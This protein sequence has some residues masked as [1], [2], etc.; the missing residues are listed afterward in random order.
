MRFGR[1]IALT[2]V[3]RLVLI[4]LGVI[5][6]VI[7]AR[8][9]GAV[10]KGTFAAISTYVAIAAMLAGFG[11]A[12]EATRVAATD[13]RRTGALLANARWTGGLAGLAA[14]CAMLALRWTLEDSAFDGIAFGLLL[15][16]GV[17]LPFT[18]TASQFHAVLLGRQRVVEYNAVES[19]DR[20]ALF[21][22]SVVLLIGFGLDVMAL[23]IATTVLAV[24]KLSVLEVMTLPDS[25]RWRPDLRLLRGVSRISARAY[26]TCLLSFLVLRSDIVLINGLLGSERTGVYS[27][28]VQLASLLL[29]LPS[30]VGSLLF[31]RIAA[32]QNAD[33]SAFTAL[34]SRHLVLVITGV[35]AILAVI[36]PWVVRA[37]FGAE[38]QDGGLALQL[39]L[40]GVW[41]MALQLILAND[42]AGR[43]YP[44]VLPIVSGGALVLNVAL[45]LWW[46][47]I[48]GI[49]GAALAS[50]IAY[51]LSFL[52]ILLYWLR[53][54]PQ[55]GLRRLFIV[56]AE[57]LLR[58]PDRL[59]QVLRSDARTHPAR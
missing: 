19:I 26:V 1:Q 38:F 46:L 22:A 36:G 4:P 39:L 11:L 45:N 49:A 48:Y 3:V 28:A 27:V 37:L 6:A 53:R 33:N 40:P 29:V 7:A 18:L 50:T 10:G 23:V 15:V 35:C 24:A 17:A 9:L 20:V 51:A 56:S 21:L 25:G 42:L 57:E 59:R 34:V 58:I 55:I 32:T 2:Y 13:G 54:F 12:I 14:L 43:D 5:N 41:C 52:S 31:P 8:W 47:P 16:A 30:A 44:L